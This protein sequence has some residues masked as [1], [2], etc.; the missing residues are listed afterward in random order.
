MKSVDKEHGLG[1]FLSTT[2]LKMS[3]PCLE[4]RNKANEMFDIINLNN[5]WKNKDVK[6]KFYNGY[7]RLLTEYYAQALI[8]YPR[9]DIDI[10]EEAVV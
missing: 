7:I 3:E 8:S 5:G 1:W 10:L 6:S 4:A 9:K 2:N